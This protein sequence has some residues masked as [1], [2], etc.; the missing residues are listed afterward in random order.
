MMQFL[1]STCTCDWYMCYNRTRDS[2]INIK[3]R[4]WAR[5]G[6]Y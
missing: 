3:W 1:T 2:L 6:S 5:I 4:N